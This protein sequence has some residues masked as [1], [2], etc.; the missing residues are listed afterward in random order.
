[1]HSAVAIRGVT[2]EAPLGSRLACIYEEGL[3]SRSV[4]SFHSCSSS[5]RCT[6]CVLQA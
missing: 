1:M 6:V 3:L 5:V 2:R 4:W